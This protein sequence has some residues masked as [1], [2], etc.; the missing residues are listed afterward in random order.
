M[1]AD[2]HMDTLTYTGQGLL[3]WFIYAVQDSW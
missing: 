1:Q 2:T 3:L